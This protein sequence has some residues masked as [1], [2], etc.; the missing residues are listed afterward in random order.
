MQDG[1][2]RKG[3][4]GR[5]GEYLGRDRRE[6]RNRNSEPRTVEGNTSSKI[7]KT[8]AVQE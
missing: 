6:G 2:G 3:S 8:L 7:K 5:F 4:T 1:T